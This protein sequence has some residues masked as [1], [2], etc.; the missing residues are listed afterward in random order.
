MQD[1]SGLFVFS[2]R[3]QNRVQNFTHL[4]SRRGARQRSALDPYPRHGFNIGSLL[5]T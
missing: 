3:V 5:N 1:D 4:P 2:I